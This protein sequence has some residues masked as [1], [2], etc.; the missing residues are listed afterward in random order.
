M[1]KSTSF[2]FKWLALGLLAIVVIGI[3][4]FAIVD[5]NNR[6]AKLDEIDRYAIITA[7]EDNGSIADHVKGDANAPVSL[8][9]YANFQCSHCASMNPLLAEAVANSN[10]QFNI[11]F[12]NFPMSNFPNSTAAAAAAEAAGLQGYWQAY[13]DKLFE[14]Q[15]EWYSASGNTRTEY[16]KRYFTEVTDDQG[17]LDQFVSDMSSEAVNA[18][19]D[20]D[21]KLG[22]RSGV[23]GTPNFFVEG[24]Q[25]ETSG[26]ELTINGQTITYEA[27]DTADDW[28][29]LLN[30]IAT[31]KVST[32]NS[33]TVETSGQ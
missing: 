29:E 10:G 24:Q 19:I 11:I 6:A 4:V 16:F 9:E 15:A 22:D 23:S 3:I 18:K 32:A 20:F 25:I 26:G 31:A 17:D 14:N 8:I 7:S 28:R 12:R 2:N 21:R 27:I 33:P 5:N 1:K 30:E 13:A